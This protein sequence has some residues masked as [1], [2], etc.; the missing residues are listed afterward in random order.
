[1]GKADINKTI[2]NDKFALEQPEGS[3]LQVLGNTPEHPPAPSAGD[4]S[5]SRKKKSAK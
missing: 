3:T 4:S 5:A 1:V 2:A